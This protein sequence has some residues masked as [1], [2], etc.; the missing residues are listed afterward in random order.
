MSQLCI[1]DTTVDPSLQERQRQLKRARLQD[2]LS[3]RLIN[4]PGPL[5]LVERNILPI[6]P[7]FENAIQGEYIV[8]ATTIYNYNSDLFVEYKIKKGFLLNSSVEWWSLSFETQYLF[9]K[10]YINS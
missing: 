8:M 3:E 4:R 10:N 6:D 5:E 1:V 9:N 7:E 2:S